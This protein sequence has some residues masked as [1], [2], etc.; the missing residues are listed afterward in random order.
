MV[1][2]LLANSGTH[3]HFDDSEEEEDDVVINTVVGRDKTAT[4]SGRAKS[5][6]AV[7][8]SDSPAAAAAAAGRTKA[9]SKILVEQVDEVDTLQPATLISISFAIHHLATRKKMCTAGC[10]R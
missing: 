9:S 1:V 4:T 10:R 8:V 2:N 7:R 5:G 6:G 3:T